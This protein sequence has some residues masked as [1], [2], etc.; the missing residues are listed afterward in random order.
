MIVEEVISLERI[1]E[2]VEILTG[3]LLKISEGSLVNWLKEKSNQCKSII[4]KM[5]VKSL[6]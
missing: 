6:L 3:G 4:K 5:K 1:K 2:F